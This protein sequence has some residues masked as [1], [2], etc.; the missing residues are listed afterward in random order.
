MEIKMWEEEKGDSKRIGGENELGGN[1]GNETESRW[2][3]K[4]D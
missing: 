1:Q 2:V 3:G 4:R